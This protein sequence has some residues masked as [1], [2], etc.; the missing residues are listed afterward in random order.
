LGVSQLDEVVFRVP[1]LLDYQAEIY[2]GEGMVRLRVK[3]HSAVDDSNRV[4]KEVHDA[5]SRVPI[6]KRCL[7]EDV[8]CLDPVAAEGGTWTSTGTSKRKIRD[9]RL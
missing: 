9:S 7:E 4:S 8:L 1:G 5:L 3:V 6:I 2:K